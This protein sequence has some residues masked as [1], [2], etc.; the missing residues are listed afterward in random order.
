MVRCATLT[1]MTTNPVIAS[2]SMVQG[3]TQAGMTTKPVI[4]SRGAFCRSVAI[5]TFDRVGDCHGPNDGPRGDRIN[6]I[7]R[8]PPLATKQSPGA[9]LGIA[10]P[11][12]NDAR[13]PQSRCCRAKC[14]CPDLCPLVMGLQQFSGNLPQRHFGEPILSLELQPGNIPAEITFRR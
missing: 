4:A 5:P 14:N 2:S 1:G 3:T 9:P 8:S 7:S 10:P 11:L 13:S 6:V 12:V